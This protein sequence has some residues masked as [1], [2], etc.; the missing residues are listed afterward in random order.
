MNFKWYKGEKRRI[1]KMKITKILSVIFILC[2][3]FAFA[4]CNSDSFDDVVE[5]LGGN[6]YIIDRP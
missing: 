3:C 4:S 2:L 5:N 1:S 6:D